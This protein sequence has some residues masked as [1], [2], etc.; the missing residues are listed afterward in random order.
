MISDRVWN[1]DTVDSV[2]SVFEQAF[3]VQYNIRIFF[4]A[5]SFDQETPC[6]MLYTRDI[7]MNGAVVQAGHFNLILQNGVEGFT[8]SI[9][10]KMQWKLVDLD[11][12][13]NKCELQITDFTKFL[14]LI[15]IFTVFKLSRDPRSLTLQRK[16][17]Y[18]NGCI[19]HTK[20]HYP[21]YKVTAT[22]A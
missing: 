16:N 11:F 21:N 7:R 3:D 8:K 22:Q 19:E 6:A 10:Q 17:L 2:L 12:M 18:D 15:A 20:T 4:K 5:I 1:A 14:K 13:L 9:F